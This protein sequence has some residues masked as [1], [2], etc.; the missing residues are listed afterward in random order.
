[1]F[2]SKSRFFH[3]FF[4][5]GCWKL[6]KIVQCVLKRSSKKTCRKLRTSTSTF[7]LRR[8]L[9]SSGS[10]QTLPP[11]FPDCAFIPPTP[12][13][14]T[15]PVF[16]HHCCICY[17]LSALWYNFLIIIIIYWCERRLLYID[18]VLSFCGFTRS[19]IN[20]R[21]NS[22]FPNDWSLY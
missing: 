7:T 1:M 21:N 2:L 20:I 8:A 15:G 11:P 12:I 17:G 14:T 10:C 6:K 16:R 22:L 18:S 19:E 5:L 4:K 9:W 13:C 3:F